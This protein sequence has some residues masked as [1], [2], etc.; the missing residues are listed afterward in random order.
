MRGNSY[1]PCLSLSLNFSP[2]SLYPYCTS[3]STHSFIIPFSEFVCSYCHRFLPPND[4]IFLLEHCKFCL[5]MI[6]PDKEHN[7]MCFLCDYHT[8]L[9]TNMRNHIVQHTG[10]EPFNCIHCDYRCSKNSNLKKHIRL[11]HDRPPRFYS[12]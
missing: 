10:V 8:Y 7:Y 6:R 3:S 11:Y 1:F 2:L 12:P 9:S 4:S 5:L